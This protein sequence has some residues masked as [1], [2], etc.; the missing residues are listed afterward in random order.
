MTGTKIGP[1]VAAPLAA[2]LA[3]SYGW[4]FM[5]LLIGLGG[6]VWLVPWLLLVKDDAPQGVNEL[7]KRTET[8]S[9]PFGQIVASPVTWGTVIATFCYVYFVYFCMTWMPAY[10]VQQ[11]HLSLSRMGYAFFSFGGM[12]IVAAL[13]GGPPI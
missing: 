13:A 3:M 9:V 4:R 11:R 12:A 6:A 8:N 10:F 5:F 2:W 7:T 1:A